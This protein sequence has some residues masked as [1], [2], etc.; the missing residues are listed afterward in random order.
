MAFP[1]RQSREHKGVIE[2]DRVIELHLYPGNW[3]NRACSFCT[4][5]GNSKGWY[6]EYTHTHLDA[7]LRT[8]P[9]HE[10]ATLKFYGGEPT[11]DQENLIWAIGYV[12]DRGFRGT[13]VIYSNGIEA[14]RLIQVLECDPLDEITASLNY[15]IATGD[16]APQMPAESLQKLEAYEA[17][18]PGKIT[19]GHAEILDVGWGSKPFK[20]DEERVKEESVCPHCYPVLK[21]DGTFHACPF[22]VEN[23]APHFQLG[24]VNS[25]SEEIAENFQ[26]FLNWLDT[27]HQPFAEAHDLAACQVCEHHLRELPQPKFVQRT[28]QER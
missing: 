6:K 14:D 23:H 1:K 17:Q 11:L 12:R 25:S 3:C 22:A 16:G 19:A 18:H 4:V 24:T 10:N 13:I 28:G 15:S 27:V 8:V 5:Y 9:Q 26:A 7:A 21:T 20:G 2:G